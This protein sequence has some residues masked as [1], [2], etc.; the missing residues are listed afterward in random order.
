[1]RVNKEMLMGLL[2]GVIFTFGLG[3]CSIIDT[4]Y[5]KDAVVVCTR[6]NTVVVQDEHGN[7]WGFIGTEYEVGKKVT[8][9]MDN[10]HTSNI[11]DDRI[12]KVK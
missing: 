1:M 7:E 5:K 12:V 2:V 11:R 10:N 9:V 3:V 6:A 4:Q 8:L